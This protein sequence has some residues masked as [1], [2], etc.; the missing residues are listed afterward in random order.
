MSDH[1]Y[2]GFERKGKNELMYSNLNAVY[3]PSQ[4]YEG[5]KDGM[6]NVNQFVI[7]IFLIS[8]RSPAEDVLVDWR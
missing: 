2:R 6:T 7:A 3:L 8:S 5:W 4:G 1:A